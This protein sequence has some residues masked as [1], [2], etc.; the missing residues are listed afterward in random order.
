MIAESWWESIPRGME[1]NIKG[2]VLHCL[3]EEFEKFSIESCITLSDEQAAV[4]GG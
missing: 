2:S 1:V 3:A 4:D